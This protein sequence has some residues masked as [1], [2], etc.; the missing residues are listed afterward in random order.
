MRTRYFDYPSLVRG[1]SLDDP[2]VAAGAMKA[3]ARLSREGK[4]TLLLINHSYGGGTEKHV[5]DL[6]ARCQPDVCV[7]ILRSTQDAGTFI[8]SFA[9]DPL[10]PRLALHPE[11]DFT[12]LIDLLRAFPVARVHIHQLFSLPPATKRL[13]ET[14][15]VPFDFTVHDYHTLCPRVHLKT[16][17]HVYCGEEG[18][19]ACTPC[20]ADWP[21]PRE[22]DI[23]AYS[24]NYAW[25]Y[26]GAERVIC[27]SLDA[28]RR[29]KT[30]HPQA[31][32][33]AVYHD[34]L[35]GARFPQV[36]APPL[37]AAEPLR[38]A[39]L[40]YL[41]KFKGA[42][43]LRAAAEMAGALR[44]PLEFWL[45]GYPEEDL[46]LAPGAP[47]RITG[48]YQPENLPGLLQQVSPHL[49]WFSVTVPETYSY[50][51]SEALSAGL[52]VAVPDIGAFAERVAGRP[53]TW[54]LPWD[55]PPRELIDF[56]TAIR[57][58]HF[59]SDKA[60]PLPA[61]YQEKD[62]PRDDDF[63]QARYLQPLLTPG[64]S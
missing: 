35:D 43:T 12:F 61:P 44:L 53:W 25:V 10:A 27:P 46:G 42:E 48:A 29:I 23:D 52:P 55:T 9:A 62:V 56:F 59:F 28:A 60:P 57:E 33:L 18:R 15:Q 47:L 54:I 64:R 30:Y 16:G 37:T 22:Q 63:Y 7:L 19:E 4:P 32:V 11:E 39:V 50:T 41:T 51:L 49:V 58:R 3:A 21:H 5:Q 24:Q 2:G 45:I 6:A 31:R 1:Q 14:L 13:I 8:L 36:A 34:R 26:A 40:G 20:L 17:R 38:I